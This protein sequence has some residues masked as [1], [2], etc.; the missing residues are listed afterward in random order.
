MSEMN[1]ENVGD[2]KI[3]EEVVAVLAEK[4]LRGVEGI[5]E[6]AGNFVDSFAA[7]WGKKIGT[8]GIGVDIKDNNAVI[9]LNVIVKYGVRIPEVAWKSQEAVKETVESMTGL[10][11]VKVNVNIEGVKF[12]AAI[13]ETVE[14]PETTEA[15]E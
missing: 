15:T 11:V 12:D 8:K 14:V 6:L 3:S 10:E 7:V 2:I 5:E 9:S 1:N 4:A 13:A